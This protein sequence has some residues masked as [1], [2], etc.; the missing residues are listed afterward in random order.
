MSSFL[1]FFLKRK[2]SYFFVNCWSTVHGNTVFD[3][4]WWIDWSKVEEAEDRIRVCVRKR[5]LTAR[6][7]KR[8]EPDIVRIRS[9][10]TVVVEELKVA[11]DLKKFIQQVYKHILYWKTYHLRSMCIPSVLCHYLVKCKSCTRNP[12]W[13]LEDL[14][15]THSNLE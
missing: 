12:Q 13:S 5:P 7:A 10:Q 2:Q 4:I 9:H 14:Q 8:N 3:C 15:W 6:E 11:V 1:C